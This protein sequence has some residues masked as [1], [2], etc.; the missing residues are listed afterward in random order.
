MGDCTVESFLR[1]DLLRDSIFDLG[2]ATDREPG[3][4]KVGEERF[5]FPFEIVALPLD[6]LEDPELDS[7]ACGTGVGR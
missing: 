4:T 2:R 1:R 6:E 3:N 7:G 5:E